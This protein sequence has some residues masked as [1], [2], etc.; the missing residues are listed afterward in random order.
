MTLE[1]LE[2]IRKNYQKVYEEE[3]NRVFELYPGSKEKYEAKVMAVVQEKPKKE[4]FFFF[5]KRKTD[6]VITIKK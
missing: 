4:R 6:K 2:E 3:L 5:K 1:N